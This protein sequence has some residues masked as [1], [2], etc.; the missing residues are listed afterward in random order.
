MKWGIHI[1]L[2]K[3]V[4]IPK[5]R[6]IE[7]RLILAGDTLNRTYAAC[8]APY[9]DQSSRRQGNPSISEDLDT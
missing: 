9:K 2:T 1:G 3:K 5:F 6:K 4:S 7:E 8:M